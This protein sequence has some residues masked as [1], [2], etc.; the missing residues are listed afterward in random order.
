MVSEMSWMLEETRHS[1]RI[2]DSEICSGLIQYTVTLIVSGT[3]WQ[4]GI[5]SSLGPILLMKI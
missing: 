4:L 2:S 3:R 5:Y 1:E